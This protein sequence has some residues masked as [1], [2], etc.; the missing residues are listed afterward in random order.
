ME[1]GPAPSDFYIPADDEEME[2]MIEQMIKF[3][4]R[5]AGAEANIESRKAEFKKALCKYE[6]E[7]RKSWLQHGQGDKRRRTKTS[8][9]YKLKPVF[10]NA[11]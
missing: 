7:K 8:Q 1:S 4:M 6:R 2:L 9:S 10:K 5:H 3:V 11:K